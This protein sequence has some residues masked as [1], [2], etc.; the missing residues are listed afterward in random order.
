[1]TA[2]ARI[3]LRLLG[4]PRLTLG[5]NPA[6]VRLSTRKVSALVAYLAM[7]PDQAASREVLATL[8]WG[9]CSDQQARQ[10]L[11][12]ALAFLRKDLGAPEYF[13]ADANV[14]LDRALWTVDALEL[15]TRS[16]SCD[17]ED[18]DRAATLF[19][20]DF[21]AGLNIEEDGF[22][23]WMGAQRARTQRAAARLCEA[24]AARPELVIDGERAVTAAERLLALDPLREDWQRLALTL[25]AR[26]RSKSEALA[27]AKA[28]AGLL[29]RELGVGLEKETRA[30]IEK[31]RSGEIGPAASEPQPIKTDA[32]APVG[33][34]SVEPALPNMAGEPPSG[35]HRKAQA[36]E[37][38]PLPPS[39]LR[40]RS[41]ASSGTIGALAFGCLIVAAGIFGSTYD[42]SAPA[43]VGDTAAILS[44]AT[45][46]AD[47]WRS[48]R[49]ATQ[50]ATVAPAGRESGLV[51]MVVMPF[52]IAGEG[53]D[54]PGLLADV[55]TDDLTNMLSRVSGLRVISRQTA[56]S[57]R[58]QRVDPAA[59]GAELGVRYLLEGS[60][61][62]RGDQL[63]VNVELVDA[64]SRQRVWTGR[65][66]RS[67]AGRG[68]VTDEIVNGLG[69]ELQIEV[70]LTEG[71]RDSNDPDVHALIFKGLNAISASGKAGVDSLRQAEKYFTEA[72]ER[73][74]SNFQAQNGLAA[75]HANMAIQL[76][77]ADPAADL[78]KAT[79]I[80]RQ[81]IARDPNANG[82][83]FVMGVVHV[84]RE[85][86]NE[87]TRFFER[88]IAL[89]PSHVMSHA[90]L[91][92]ALVRLGRPQEGLEHILYAMRLSPRDPAT[93]FFLAFAGSAELELKRYAKAIDYFDRA[94]VLNPGQPR[95]LL[96]RVAAHALSGNISAA[97]LQLETLQKARPHLSREKL[98]GMYAKSA[99]ESQL[100]Q[101]IQLA[102]TPQA[103]PWQSPPLP[104]KRVDDTGGPN[105]PITAIAILPFTTYGETAGS[106]QTI[107]DIITDDL[108]N[109]L[110]RVAML[111][112]ISRQTMRSYLGEK[113]DISAVG[114][115]LGVR[116]VLEGNM[117][118][119]GDRLRVNVELIDPATRLPA[120]SARIERDRADQHAVQD[121][122][123]GRLARELHFQVYHAVGER[124]SSDPGATQLI[125]AGWAAILDHG[126]EGVGALQRAEAA[127]MQAGERDPGNRSSKAGLGAYHTLV[128]SLQLVPDWRAHLVKAEELV[129]Q[130][131]REF[132][133]GA[134]QY[135]YL[136]IIQRMRGELKDAL[137]SL[138]RCLEIAPS[139]APCH[140]HLGHALAQMGRPGEGIEHINYAMRLSP[141]DMSRP[142]W[143]RFAGEA[144]IELGKFERAI[145]L[146]RQSYDANPRQPRTLRSLAAAYALSGN[147]DEAY[148]Y[149][150]ELKASAPHLSPEGYLKRPLQLDGT[151]PELL[152]GLR[153]AL[154]ASDDLWRSPRS[155][156]DRAAAET[157]KSPLLTFA[158]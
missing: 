132:P 102:L 137:E 117:R 45:P 126:T 62:M 26:H 25:Y 120:W 3:R 94:L 66:D 37:I 41:W 68:A 27:Q 113:I 89:S 59:I 55:M 36:G 40:P 76:Y 47:P 115:Q 34:H 145:A 73:S 16:K 44:P 57:Y 18:L 91:G 9:S 86:M 35:Q 14:R 142:H 39:A 93:G 154:A 78:A 151:Q 72:L 147:L 79:A 46:S 129:R 104:E 6:P 119:H 63:N 158:D 156:A 74:P 123:V 13:T 112:V 116:Y 92:R 1:M 49:L 22:A 141:R 106:I 95:T 23:E 10:S 124:A 21:L 31:I 17:P 153:Q 64:K 90:Q 4:Q 155:V 107:A 121:E 65:Y 50:P 29:Q 148:K 134:A 130:S 114:T 157:H 99:P 144:E 143:L 138:G 136:S 70:F 43:R 2:P 60:V 52:T 51:A 58:G 82:P 152:R 24:F 118:M 53:G 103:D 30:L 7:S 140:A 84:A 42:R 28:F 88:S 122:I 81:L 11:R 146:L 150:A 96:S 149:L 20:G 61:S 97:R 139:M 135:F 32:V 33:V 38:L 133:E 108:T 77:S 12:Q 100:R 67:G 5:E 75:Y 85:E 87:A 19:C 105:G 71:E 56:Q 15:E 83:H 48:P 109:S 110:S 98:I 128:G 101:G 131:I 127:F 111:R 80:L 54:G 125:Y 69:R 8:L